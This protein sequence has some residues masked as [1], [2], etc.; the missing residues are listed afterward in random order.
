MI[1]TVS[2]AVFGPGV[3]WSR[4]L[5][6]YVAPALGERPKSKGR[7]RALRTFSIGL[8]AALLMGMSACGSDDPQDANEPEGEFPVEVTTS[9]FP[10]DQRLGQTSDLILGVE[11]VGDETVP[12]LAFTIETDDGTADGS[13]KK[14]SDQPGLANPNRSVWILENKFPREV[15][16][17]PPPGLSGGTRAQTNTYGF[18]PLEPG[19][20]REII[21][22]VTPVKAGT[23]TLSYE[24]AAG[25]DGNAR[26]VTASGDEVKGSFNVTI[27][28]K[29]PKARVNGK[30]EVIT[31]A[32][33]GSSGS[34]SGK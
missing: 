29:P 5:P 25:L 20:T 9:E 28:D 6:W 18:G 4:G 15:G 19:E 11:N 1:A 31:E 27:T 24:V 34:G 14:R 10:V 30:G 17:P 13:F 12:E 3:T 7:P 2:T 16:E 32:P 8:V 33:D 23:Y 22:R 21:W 26:A